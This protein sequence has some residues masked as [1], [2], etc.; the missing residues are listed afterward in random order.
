[1]HGTWSSVLNFMLNPKLCSSG[2]ANESI[3]IATACWVAESLHYYSRSACKVSNFVSH[4]LQTLPIF[5]HP[6]HLYTVLPQ[7]GL[8]FAKM[9]LNFKRMDLAELCECMDLLFITCC[10]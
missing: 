5:S 8:Y 4:I 7:Q 3:K 6:L 9:R 1:M 10:C 2:E